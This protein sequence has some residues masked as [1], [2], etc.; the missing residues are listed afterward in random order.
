M[1]FFLPKHLL[2]KETGDGVIR[3]IDLIKKKK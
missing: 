1:V 3:N 2:S